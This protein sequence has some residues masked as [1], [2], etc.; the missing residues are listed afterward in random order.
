METP[1][2]FPFYDIAAVF[3]LLEFISILVLPVRTALVF[4]LVFTIEKQNNHPIGTLSLNW[5]DWNNNSCGIGY[6]ISQEKS[7]NGIIAN[8]CRCLINHLIENNKL[9]RFVIEAGI[10]NL[11][12]RKVAEK[13]GMRLEGINKDREIILSLRALEKADERDASMDPRD[14]ALTISRVRLS[15]SM[16]TVSMRLA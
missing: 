3:G 2:L 16:T 10:D 8:S 15:P 6:W 9:H 4:V 11:P 14:T 5:I 13:L 1:L 7:G 12:S